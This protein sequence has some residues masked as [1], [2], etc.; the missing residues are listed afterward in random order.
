MR[1]ALLLSALAAAAA[2]GQEPAAAP[3]A[4]AAVPGPFRCYVVVD[5]RYEPKAKPPQKPE[6]RD[7]R[8]RTDKMH[9]FVVEQGLNPVLAVLTRAAPAEDGV[10]GRL[11]KELAALYADKT[12]RGSS[13]GAFVVFLAL[14]KEFPADMQRTADG[15]FVRDEKAKAVRDLAASANAPR[16]PFGLAAR[17][18][19]QTASWG[20]KDEDETVVVLYNR[21][22]VTGR[23]AFPAGGVDDAKLKEILVAV[24]AEAKK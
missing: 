17:T 7:P 4:D 13:L 14:E 15:G 18:S 20:L 22:K 5:N 23:W 12:L 21:L 6:D 2:T 8:D 19:D 9:S 3:K 11:T 24:R 10:A 16:V 1:T